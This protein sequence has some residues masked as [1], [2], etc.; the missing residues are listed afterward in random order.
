[1]YSKEKRMKA[2]ELY[3]KYSKSTADTIRE[4]GY[5]CRTTL[6]S[7]HKLYL[8]ERETGVIHD[9]YK[10]TPKFTE[11]QKQAAVCHY[12]DHG[13]NYSR[14]SRALGYPN[15]ESLRQWCRELVPDRCRKRR[16]GLQYTEEQKREAVAALCTREGSAQEVARVYG[17]SRPVLYQW[18]NNLLGR[19]DQTAMKDFGDE[20]ILKTKEELLEEIEGLNKQIKR[21]KLERDVLEVT[22]EIIKKDPGVDPKNLGNREKALLVDA[23]RNDHPLKNLLKCVKMSRSSYFYQRA[24]LLAE[25]KYGELKARVRALF[26]EN[27]GRYGYRRIHALLLRE[28]RRVS[29]KIVRRIMT[30]YALVVFGKKKRKYSSYKGENAPAARNLLERDFHASAPNTK[31]LTD[32]TEFQIP[33]GKIYL[34]PIVDCFDG[35]LV[36]WTIGPSPDAGLVNTMLDMAVASLNENEK[37]I[38]HSDRGAHYR[39]PGWLERME[40]AGLTRSMSKKACTADNAACEGVFGRVKNEMFYNR[41]WSKVSLDEFMEILNGYLYWYNEKR[42]KISLG[43]KSPLEYRR[44]LDLAA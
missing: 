32:I 18:K 4:L 17:V 10:R 33:A 37:P 21:L 23:L 43:A 36:S 14:T 41:E 16:G 6:R 22:A 28:G 31:W 15:R 12:L 35:M 39:W 34:S 8:R 7:W 5:P 11:E 1:M 26:E 24:R 20:T 29:E 27:G 9:R 19:E 44:S 3:I 30:E 2:V 42:I 25:D 13:C 38:V 40:E